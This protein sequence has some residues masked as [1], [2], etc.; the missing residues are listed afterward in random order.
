VSGFTPAI[1]ANPEAE[2]ISE[3]GRWGF[4]SAT[5]LP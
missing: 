1:V 4:R 2:S 5:S 3:N